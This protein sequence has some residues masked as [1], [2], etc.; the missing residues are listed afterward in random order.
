MGH[1]LRTAIH[2]S[3]KI[4]GTTK[5]NFQVSNNSLQMALDPLTV[6]VPVSSAFF[7]I[8]MTHALKSSRNMTER[9]A[10]L[11]FTAFNHLACGLH[12]Y[13]VLRFF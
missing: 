12:L 13:T 10:M 5:I 9:R 6:F 4:C 7:Y 1:L 3:L 11:A 2:P 8:A